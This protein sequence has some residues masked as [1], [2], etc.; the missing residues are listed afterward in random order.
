M[1]LLVTGAAGR[2][3]C[4]LVRLMVTKGHGV[5]AFDLPQAP[6][7]AIQDLPGVESF[8]GDMTKPE[9]VAEACR[10]VGGVFHLAALLPPSSERNRGVTMKVN[11]EGTRSLIGELEKMQ[12]V[13]LVLASSVSTYGITADEKK[14]IR[15]DH[16][17]TA[18]DFYSESKI[19]AERIARR[20]SIP[21]VVLRIS[22]IS[23][24]DLVEL[25][26]VIPYRSDQRV[27]HVY[28]EDAARALLSAFE[29]KKAYGGIFNVAGGNTWQVTGSEYIKLFYEALGVEVEPRFSETCTALDWYDTS[30]GSFLEYQKTTLNGLLEKLVAVGERLGLR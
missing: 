22:A 12:G 4:E 25:P 13:P 29:N 15:E 17:L 20:S 5:I 8:R 26:D 2:L 21:S 24:A 28:V 7:E 19:E 11:V 23:V 9:D 18:H 6:F 10:G 27:E 16:P 1:K 14:P 30:R 3:G